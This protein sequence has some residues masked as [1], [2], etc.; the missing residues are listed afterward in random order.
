MTQ[1]VI[2]SPDFFPSDWE[3]PQID[4]YER[5]VDYRRRQMDGEIDQISPFSPTRAR[6]AARTFVKTDCPDHL[7]IGH[8]NSGLFKIACIYRRMGMDEREIFAGLQE[9]NLIRC[10]PPLD[11]RE[12]RQIA[13]SAGAYS[14]RG[15]SK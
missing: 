8:R 5:K 12:V 10:T 14:I 6:G 11:E 9:E 4:E 1:F 2:R 3:R 7:G 15:G 13:K